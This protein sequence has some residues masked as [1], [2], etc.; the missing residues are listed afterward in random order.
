MFQAELHLLPGVG[1]SADA[2]GHFR[3]KLLAVGW[4]GLGGGQA[5]IKIRQMAKGNITAPLELL[6]R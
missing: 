3:C 6:G 1:E 5:C 2:I 4:L